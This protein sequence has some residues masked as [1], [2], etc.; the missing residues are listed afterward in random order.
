[1][2]EKIFVIFNTTNIGDV[3]V[4]NTLAQNIKKY[5]PDSKIVFVCN[6]PMYDVAKY[7]DGIDDVVVFDKKNSNSLKGIFSFI[8]NFPYKKPFAAFVTYSNERNL[9]ISRLIGAKHIIS[10]HKF[11]LWNTNEKY[12]MQDYLHIKDK[13]GGMI[14]PLTNEHENLPIKYIPPEINNPLTQKIKNINKP[15]A[16]SLTSNFFYKDMKVE[17]CI[18]LINLLNAEGY[19]PIMTGAGSIAA[20]FVTEVKKSGCLEFID[21]VNCTSFPE[22]ANI[23]KICGSC[24]SVDTG[25]LHLA[26]ALQVPV[27]GIFYAGESDKWGSDTSL[28]PAKILSGPIGV[29]ADIKPKEIIQAYKEIMGVCK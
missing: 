17:D 25:T 16:L 10:H 29:I 4:T 23:L 6:T 2:E 24:I 3:L 22:L 21:L 15:V 19:T 9:F 7:Q 13:W 1:M 8:K 18:E 26:N 27:V 14:E 20:K 11:K 5:Y 28:Y 12:K